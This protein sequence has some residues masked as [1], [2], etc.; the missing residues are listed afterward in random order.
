MHIYRVRRIHSKLD[1]HI[2]TCQTSFHKLFS[3]K[4]TGANKHTNSNY[5]PDVQSTLEKNLSTE[6]FSGSS[7]GK[8][9]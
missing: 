5:S 9:S 8:N 6:T 7:K 3:F 1:R 2:Q 4:N